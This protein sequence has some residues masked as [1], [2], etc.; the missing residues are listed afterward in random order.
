MPATTLSVIIIMVVVI[1]IPAVMAIAIAA[2][3]RG[4]VAHLKLRIDGMPAIEA[5]EGGGV[6]A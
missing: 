6:L 5:E 3:A 2:G 4:A 1:A